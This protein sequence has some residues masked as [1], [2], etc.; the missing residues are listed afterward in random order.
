MKLPKKGDKDG[1]KTKRIEPRSTI[2]PNENSVEFTRQR[3]KQIKQ[4]G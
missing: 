1:N 4:K 3:E 2:K